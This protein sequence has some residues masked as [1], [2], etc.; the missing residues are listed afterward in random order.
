MLDP[1][2]LPEPKR[3]RCACGGQRTGC[4]RTVTSGLYCH[5]CAMWAAWKLRGEVPAHGRCLH[6][7]ALNAARRRA[8][9]GS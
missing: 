3:R 4:G 1:T 7:R 5:A 6:E 9:G 2:R 8:G